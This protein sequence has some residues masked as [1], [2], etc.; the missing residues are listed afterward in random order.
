MYARTNWEVAVQWR[1]PSSPGSACAAHRRIFSLVDVN[2]KPFYSLSLLLLLR[3]YSFLA[4]P[5]SPSP[6][7]E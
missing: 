5:S 1:N 4:I 3:P 7:L 2:I 6:S